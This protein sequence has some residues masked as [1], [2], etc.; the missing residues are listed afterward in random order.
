M[1]RW[2]RQECALAL[3]WVRRL[4]LLQLLS[5]LRPNSFVQHVTILCKRET[6][7]V[8]LL[9]VLLVVVLVALLVLVVLVL[10][11]AAIGICRRKRIN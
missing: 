7:A 10:V 3:M 1:H 2:Q 8:V 11:M 9:V 5:L 4:C 6:M